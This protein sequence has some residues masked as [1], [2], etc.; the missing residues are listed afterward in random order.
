MS[1]GWA[2]SA[3]RGHA[4]V[5]ASAGADYLEAQAALREQERE[6]V[7]AEPPV[8]EIGHCQHTARARKGTPAQAEARLA[9]ATADGARPD[10]LDRRE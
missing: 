5:C 9:A 4:A 2:E 8:E 1:K 3:G 7:R 10:L 6:Q